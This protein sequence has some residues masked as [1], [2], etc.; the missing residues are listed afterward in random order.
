M[1]KLRR[2]L[3]R[4]L[5]PALLVAGSPAGAEAILHRANDSE[6]ETLDPQ[7]TTGGPDAQVEQDLFEGLTRLDPDKHPLPGVA[8]RWETSPDGLTWT[9]HLRRDALWSNGEP[10]TAGDFLYSFRRLVDPATAA[11]FIDPLRDIVNAEAIN[12]GKIKDISTL[13]VEA[14]DPRTI[15]LRLAHPQF[16]M[17]ILMSNRAVYAL[18]RATLEKWGNEW[19]RPGKIV[20]NGPFVMESWVPHDTIAL[21]KSPTYWGR[22][23]I[24]LQ[25]V[26]HIVVDNEA[27]G[28]R[29]FQAGELDVA[30]VPAREFASVKQNMADRL[31]TGLARG[32][33]FIAV[34][35]TRA[36]LGT[37]HRLREGLSLAIDRELFVTKI[38]ARGEPPA[39]AL[40]SPAFHD[41]TPQTLP[42][43]DTPQAERNAMARKLFAE[44]GYDEG[45]K[46]ALTLLY[47][48][49]DEV[50]QMVLGIKAMWEKTLPVTLTPENQEFQVLLTSID[51]QNYQLAIHGQ[52]L[53]EDEPI[54]FLR[55][56]VS[57][58][59][60]FNEEKY[61]SPEFD[62]LIR[63]AL[64][65]MDPLKRRADLEAAERVIM[66]DQPVIPIYY[67]MLQT[68]VSPHLHG[69]VD[70]DRYPE[71][72]Y[73]WLD[74]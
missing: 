59:G 31:H 42:W 63:S 43:K 6:P 61:N 70:S 45:H 60:D 15:I 28:L 57:D 66:A 19:T 37:D 13:G 50:R 49:N 5:L 29:R 52:T 12:S 72:R 10:V 30:R 62:R 3:A 14:P 55:N 17:P 24:R 35:M 40:M 36:P 48:T 67:P 32:N 27:A 23:Q 46:L 21:R 58:A 9:F 68:L 56:L 71:S 47:T 44:A 69:W 8:E 38:F 11:A 54:Q 41:Y 34:N 25:A 51:H 65:S 1:A 39:Y 64:V 73:L 18:H 22:D 16:I 2:S 26:Q 53:G 20:G 4:L 7:R 33:Y 74:P